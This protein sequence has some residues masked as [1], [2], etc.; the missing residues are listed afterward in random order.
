VTVI[1]MAKESNWKWA[2]F[3]VVFNTLLAYTLA[4]IIYQTGA[5]LTG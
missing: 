2:A 5:A 1:A 4:V 3:A